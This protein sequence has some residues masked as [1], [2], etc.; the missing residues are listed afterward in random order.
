MTNASELAEIPS[1]L[2]RSALR[3]TVENKIN[4]NNYKIKVKSASQAGSTNFVGIVYRVFYERR[5]QTL[6]GDD[7][8]SSIILK[9][10][11]QNSAR[12]QKFCSRPSFLREIYM[13]EKV[14]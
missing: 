1:E 5:D 2:I 13:Y 11:P 12:R 7:Y 4:S 8:K 3:K 6:E 14:S 9:V 10:S